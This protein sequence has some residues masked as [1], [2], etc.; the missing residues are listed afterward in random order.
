MLSRVWLIATLWTVTRQA[1]LS[2]GF[3]RQQYW[4]GVPFPAPGQNT[5]V[6]SLS[7]LQG[8]FPTPGSN[9]GLLHCRQILYQLIHKGSPQATVYFWKW[10]TADET[11]LPEKKLFLWCFFSKMEEDLSKEIEKIHREIH[12]LSWLLSAHSE[13]GTNKHCTNGRRERLAWVW[14]K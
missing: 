5:G 13:V 8:I 11:C 10:I 14:G 12:Y 1:P 3:P 7:L 2:M 9:P 6:G 4:S